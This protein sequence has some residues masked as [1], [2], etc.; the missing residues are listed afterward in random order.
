M[1][2]YIRTYIKGCHTCMQNKHTTQKT[3]STM[4][5]LP[6]PLGPWEWTQSDHIIGLP[7]SQGHDAIYVVMDRLT[8]MTHFIPTNTCA[9]AEDLVQSHL[10]HVWK[11]HGVPKIHNTDRGSTFTADYT[12][13]FFKALNIDQWFSTAYHPQTQGQ[14]ENNNK[15]VE[16][17]I[18]MFCN[19]QQ[20]N[21]ADLLHLAE[22]TY[23]NH[24]H[25]SIGMSP[26][27]ANFGYDMTLTPDN[28]TRGRDTPLCLA[29]LRKPHQQCSM[30]IT[31]A[32]DHQ[33]KLYNKQRSEQPPLEE[34]N[35]VWISSRDL[36]TDRPSP[37]LEALCFG[38]YRI[39]EVMGPLTYCIQLPP[40]WR[41]N[42]VFHRS[43]LT[44]VN[45]AIDGQHN[46]VTNP[47]NVTQ[48][49]HIGGETV[50]N[51]PQ[52]PTDTTTHPRHHAHQ[53]N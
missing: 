10:K 45:P 17:Y 13:R 12:W 6:V 19:Q 16:T 32:Q 25:P 3:P 52:T 35:E 39:K 22:F 8:K 36:S 44:A 30:W 34:G 43:K 49:P 24:H 7:R 18:R 29:L 23:N 42:N 33:K 51:D 40:H 26:F 38:P 48:T 1:A 15:W 50:N 41:V 37:K 9:T 5:P 47:S 2:T 4:Q 21:W 14:V 20:N 46:H 53:Q 11:H 28:E 27:R 31:Q